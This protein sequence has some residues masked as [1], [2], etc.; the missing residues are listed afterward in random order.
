MPGVGGSHWVPPPRRMRRSVSHG[1]AKQGAG[2]VPPVQQ[3][4]HIHE[5]DRLGPGQQ[6]CRGGQLDQQ[7][8]RHSAQLRYVPEGELPHKRAQ[9]GRRVGPAEQGAHPAVTDHVQ[10]VDA[11]RAGDHARHERGDLSCRGG[12]HHPSSEGTF[13]ITKLIDAVA[14]ERGERVVEDAAGTLGAGGRSH[15]TSYGSGA[16]PRPRASFGL[17]W[18]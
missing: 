2:F 1:H 11:V 12:S 15:R 3:R 8:P 6:R 18:G 13:P 9:R 7:P 5:G 14:G 17:L 4:V 10:I 16:A